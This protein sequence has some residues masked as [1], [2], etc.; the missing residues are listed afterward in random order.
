MN[1]KLIQD[2]LKQLYANMPLA[3]ERHYIQIR[4]NGLKLIIYGGKLIKA[5]DLPAIIAAESFCRLHGLKFM[6]IKVSGLINGKR[7]AN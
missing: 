7:A 5:V 4:E 2:A 1:S 3:G 6:L